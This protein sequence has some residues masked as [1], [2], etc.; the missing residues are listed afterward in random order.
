MKKSKP[1]EEELGITK[2]Q[3]IQFHFVHRMKL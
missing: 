3:L 1:L 2:D